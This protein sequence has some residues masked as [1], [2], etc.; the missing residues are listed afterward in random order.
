MG[1]ESKYARV[2][3]EVTCPPRCGSSARP[4]TTRRRS[5]VV[6]PDSIA[7]SIKSCG[8][9]NDRQHRGACARAFSTDLAEA[10]SDYEAAT[11]Q[12]RDYEE[13]IYKTPLAMSNTFPRN[14]LIEAENGEAQ[15][16][17]KTEARQGQVVCLRLDGNRDRKC[18]ERQRRTEGEV[19]L[20]S[21][22]VESW[23]SDQSYREITTSPPISC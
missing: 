22:G 4:S 1:H 17:P 20:A 5:A 23:F 8:P 19:H 16:R 13:L 7:A 14:D 15:S 12:G 10:K 6:A 18:Q 2:I 3:T 9:R 21:H 11:S